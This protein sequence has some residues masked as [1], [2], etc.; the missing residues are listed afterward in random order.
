MN[1]VKDTEGIIL[2]DESPP[3]AGLLLRRYTYHIVIIMLAKE[4]IARK[5]QEIVQLSVVCTWISVND[6]C[7][8]KPLGRSHP[9]A[10]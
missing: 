6:H 4:I 7:P 8:A 9:L 1:E 3:P 2:G 5:T 10:T